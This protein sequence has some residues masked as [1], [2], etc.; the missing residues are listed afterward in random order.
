[1][2][3]KELTKLLVSTTVAGLGIG[4]LIGQRGVHEI[5]AQCDQLTETN[6]RMQDKCE[7]LEMINDNLREAN[8]WKTEL[9][10]GEAIVNN[11]DAYVETD[12]D[13]FTEEAEQIVDE[14]SDEEY[15]ATLEYMQR[16]E[17]D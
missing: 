5:A 17:L 10:L 4:F 1:M 3:W 14:M 6:K 15:Q 16:N 2:D 7:E 8:R 11:Y 13:I 12:D 9:M